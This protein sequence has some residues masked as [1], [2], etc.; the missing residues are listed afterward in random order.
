MGWGFFGCRRYTS[1]VL[2]INMGEWI[3][4]CVCVCVYRQR[5]NKTE[6][7][8]PKEKSKRG[9]PQAEESSC[10]LNLLLPRFFKYIIPCRTIVKIP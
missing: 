8:V 5:R 7:K 4:V 6:D 3:S 10:Y 1:T 9:I 2:T